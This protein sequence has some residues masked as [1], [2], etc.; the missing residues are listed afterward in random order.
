MFKIVKMPKEKI[1]PVLPAISIFTFLFLP[2][3]GLV[4]YLDGD[5]EFL[6]AV[7]FFR[8][9]YLTN[10]TPYHPPLK[11]FLSSLFF[12][13]FGFYSYSLLGYFFGVVGIIALYSIAKKLFDQKTAIVSSLLLSVSGMYISTGVFS[14]NDFL[15]TVFLLVSFA[16]YVNKKYTLAA[17]MACFVVLSKESGIFFP[18]SMILV[19]AF[20]KKFRLINMLPFLVLF[21]WIFFLHS[22]GH[23][24]WNSWNFSETRQHGSV[25]TLL[26][27]VFQG[28]IFN[29]YAYENWLHLFVF[30]YHWVLWL[31]ALFVLPKI[32]WNKKLSIIFLFSFLY[33]LLI[34]SFQTYS[35]TRYILPLLPFLYLEVSLK[36]TQTKFQFIFLPL[37]FYTVLMSLFTSSDPISNKIWQKNQILNEKFYINKDIDGNDGITYNMQFLYLTRERNAIIHSKACKEYVNPLMISSE[38]LAILTIPQCK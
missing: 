23:T 16:L 8:G 32:L 27:N 17:V 15:M 22:T 19:E 18:V 5:V 37:V 30:N 34:L 10:W 12:Y 9:H 3:V 25:V 13:P 7:N 11:L 33:S 14:V 31:V 29:K 28:K 36:I 35:I 1:I 24:L 20:Q 6:I 4:P 26:T 2:F 38:T 21:G